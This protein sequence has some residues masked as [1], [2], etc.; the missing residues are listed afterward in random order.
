MGDTRL[1]YGPRRRLSEAYDHV[2]ICAGF[3]NS[4]ND[5][6][7]SNVDRA[8]LRE[9]LVVDD[10]LGPV[11]KRFVGTEIYKIGP[12]ADLPVTRAERA[13]SPALD[14]IPANSAAAF[15]YGPRTARL[16]EM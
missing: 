11:A 12:C 2:V 1:T 6:I 14:A 13:Q 15:R 8:P 4:I 10:E 7:S 16:A 9:E 3:T 5:I